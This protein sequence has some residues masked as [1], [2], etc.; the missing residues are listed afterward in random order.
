MTDRAPVAAELTAGLI[1][2]NKV[3]EQGL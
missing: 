3:Y 2:M 1:F